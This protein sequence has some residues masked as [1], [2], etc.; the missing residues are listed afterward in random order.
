ME[1]LE[2]LKLLKE[3]Q[4]KIVDDIHNELKIEVEKRETIFKEKLFEILN[5]IA[6]TASIRFSFESS[7]TYGEVNILDE[8]GKEIFGTEVELR[9]S[10]DYQAETSKLTLSTGTC[11]SFD[12]TDVGQI[13][14]YKVIGTLCD[15]FEEIENLCLSLLDELKPFYKKSR[16]EQDKLSRFNYEEEDILEEIEKK[17]VL[18]SITIGSLYKSNISIHDARRFKGYRLIRLLDLKNKTAI[19]EVGYQKYGKINTDEENP[20][21]DY[22]TDNNGKPIFECADNYRMNKDE[23]IQLILNK[24]L[25]LC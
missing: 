19:F 18:E 4:Q 14:K 11:G 3:A 7:W 16:I 2:E 21:W 20:R 22:L 13:Q 25:E 12:K 24:K 9:V 15:H 10:K 5:P 23:F 1:R 8:N 6:P 17:K